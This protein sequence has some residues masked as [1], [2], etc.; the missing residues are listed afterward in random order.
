M[1][2]NGDVTKS[3]YDEIL[4]LSNRM[5]DLSVDFEAGIIQIG[6]LIVNL[7]TALFIIIGLYSYHNNIGFK[8]K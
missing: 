2:R 6:L 1:V 8:K 3:E 5:K 4:N 7:I